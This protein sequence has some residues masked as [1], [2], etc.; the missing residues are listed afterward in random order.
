[1]AVKIKNLFGKINKRAAEEFSKM[2]P[3][4]FN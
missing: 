4:V 1:M 3:I 2:S